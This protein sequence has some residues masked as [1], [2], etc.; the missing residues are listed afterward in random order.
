MQTYENQGEISIFELIDIFRRNL[1][2]IIWCVLVS[3][4]IALFLSGVS[5]FLNR[6]VDTFNLT[7]NISLSG[8]DLSEQKVSIITNTFSHSNIVSPS[9]A[10]LDITS[11]DYSVIAKRSDDVGILQL[12][13][14]GPDASKLTDLSNEV[15]NLVKPLV[16]TA[17]PSVELRKLEISTPV[18]IPQSTQPNVNWVGNSVLGIMLG[19]MLSVFY[20]FVM[21]FMS[22][23]IVQDNDLESLFNTK[24]LGRFVGKPKKQTLRKFFE[25]R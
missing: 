8:N 7:T 19:G 17:F 15:F 12:V 11:S 3:L 18:L 21:Y 9:K 5:F 14:E 16:E 2:F 1:I 23:Y 20:I 6:E 4:L 10:K 25:V 22:P 24:I 13:V